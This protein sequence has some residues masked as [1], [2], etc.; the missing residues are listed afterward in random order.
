MIPDIK[1]SHFLSHYTKASL[2]RSILRML[3]EMKLRKH[4]IEKLSVMSK[5]SFKKLF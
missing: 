5:F 3:K 1:N 4:G 2:Q